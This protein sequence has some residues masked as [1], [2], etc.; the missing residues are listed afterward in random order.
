VS[1]P[2]LYLY[3]KAGREVWDAEMWLPDGCRRVWRTGIA[4]HDAAER[5]AQERLEA[6]VAATTAAVSPAAGASATATD[7]GAGVTAQVASEAAAPVDAGT[8]PMTET[9]TSAS[10]AEQAA[11]AVVVQAHGATW[12]ERFDRWFFGELATLFRQ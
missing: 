11:P 10:V 9:R 3:R 8:E 2:R 4:D 6:L 5:A 7:D 1:E 12:S